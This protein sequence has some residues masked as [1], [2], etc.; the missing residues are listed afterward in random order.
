MFS[1]KILAQCL[2]AASL[3][4]QIPPE[5]LLTMMEV[6]GGRSGLEV[7]NLN[8]TSDLGLMQINTCWLP[9]ASRLWNVNHIQARKMLRDNDCLNI[10]MAA[11]I[12]KIKIREG[13]GD[14][15][16]GIARYHHA[17]PQYHVPYLKKV[18]KAYHR[19]RQKNAPRFKKS[20][21]K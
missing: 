9:E 1:V 18:M 8:G 11:H 5:A 10:T 3:H 17:H 20:E 19:Q 4:N 7:K 16:K 21:G 13:G 14:I 6:E 12:L 15:F 2:I